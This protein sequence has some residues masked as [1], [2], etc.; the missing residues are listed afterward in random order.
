[1]LVITD[2]GPA[3]LSAG[4]PDDED[5]RLPRATGSIFLDRRQLLS[6]DA[7]QRR[8]SLPQLRGCKRRLP[9]R[10]GQV[11]QHRARGRRQR[12]AFHNQATNNNNA[13][14]LLSTA[15]S[16]PGRRPLAGDEEQCG[17]AAEHCRV[18][19]RRT[20]MRPAEHGRVTLVLRSGNE[21]NEANAGGGRSERDSE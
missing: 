9:R 11:D 21:I 1:M 2:L 7:D 5:Q 17:P 16:P 19:R 13:G 20:T 12:R 3:Y 14:R 10:L 6:S 4:P 15:A 8:I 18:R